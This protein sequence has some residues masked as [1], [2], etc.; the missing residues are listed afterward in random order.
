MAKRGSAA[1][2][3]KG[4]VERIVKMV[5]VCRIAFEKLLLI[6]RQLPLRSSP[7]C[8]WRSGVDVV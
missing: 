5:Q 3:Q 4:V 1:V 8:V 6:V 2:D 7:C